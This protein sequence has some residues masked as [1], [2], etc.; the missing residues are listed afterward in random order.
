MSHSLSSI[1][2]ATGVALLAPRVS[3]ES[4]PMT[5]NYFE[6][7]P[8]ELEGVDIVEHLDAPLPLD[9]EFT[10][11]AGRVVRLAEYFT[12]DKPV[13]LTLNFYRCEMLCTLAL[14]GLVDGMNGLEWS[15]G[16]QFRV[17]TFSI[18]PKET[19][20]LARAKKDAYLV[21]YTREGA[22]AGWT[23]HV[24]SEANIKTLADAVGFGFRLQSDGQY[25]HAACAILCTPDGRISR[26]LYGLVYQP[27][28]LRLALTEAGEGK[29]GSALDRFILWCHRYDPAAKGYVKSAMRVMQLGGVVTIVFMAAGLFAL[30]RIGPARSLTPEQ[31]LERPT[32]P[33]LSLNG[34]TS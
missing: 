20:E 11:D 25:A 16:D 2:V 27:Q 4:A 32:T 31:P 26:Y 3:A 12:G 19:H 13:I 10:D 21:P 33:S 23:F 9:L 18:N 29:I 30:W 5:P 28:D 17:I 24:G 6:Q 22:A 8:A 7:T 15:A 14:N 34:A 1:L